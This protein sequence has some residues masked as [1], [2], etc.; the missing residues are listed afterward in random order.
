M[1]L[2]AGF[3]LGS[4][5]IYPLE[6][7]VVGENHDRRIQPKTMDVLVCLAEASGEVVE[8]DDLLSQVWHGRAQ[9]D[10][11]LT[12]R[13][14]ELRKTLGDTRSEPKYIATIPK[15]GYQLLQTAIP[16]E[17][18]VG[19]D[20]KTGGPQLSER[21][22]SKRLATVKK[23]GA[24]LAV[25]IIA[26]IIQVLVERT[27]DDI[28]DDE[29]T[30]TSVRKANVSPKSV[31]VLNFADLS[32]EQD[33]GWFADGLA[34]EVLNA[35]TRTPDLRV[36]SR[37]SSDTYRN[38]SKDASTIG[39]ELGV[40][41]VLQGSVRRVGDRLRVNAQLV[42]AEDGFHVWSQ[43]YDRDAA[44]VIEIQ[45]D[46]ALQIATA[47]ET[48]M[49]PEALADMVR[50]GTNSVEAY[51]DYIRGISATIQALAAFS[52]NQVLEAN[53]FFE[54]ARQIDPEFSA[55]H[56]HAANFWVY[57]LSPADARSGLTDLPPREI[58]TEFLS[59]MNLAIEYA[60]NDVD[61]KALMAKKAQVE[62]RLRDATQFYQ[63]YLKE[64]PN[65][66]LAW[67]DLLR[68]AMYASDR[69]T[70]LSVFEHYESIG[71]S[72]V[73]AAIYYMGNAYKWIDPSST[74]DFGIGAME[75]WPN[76]NAIR[77]QTHRS[78]LWAER[79]EEAAELAKFYG[80][81]SGGDQVLLAR[82]ACAEG[83]R[84]S[85]LKMLDDR[86]AAGNALDF[87]DYFM[88]R[89]LSDDDSAV[90]VLRLYESKEV[91]Y[92]LATWLHYTIVDARPF[93]SLM[94]VLDRE[95]VDRPPPPRIP[96]A[97]PVM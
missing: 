61:R 95:N 53:A 26:A 5:H 60:G 1:N 33:Q 64:R 56:R 67:Q 97:C 92:K 51:R 21:Q 87:T 65:D 39:S 14:G 89:F 43:N 42:R 46:L 17:Q 91:P 34:E 28:T 11:P 85:V 96:F 38:T 77:Y 94:N 79:V 8:R 81:E 20:S 63:E 22:K 73:Q 50:V 58:L 16:I 52:T 10:E 37:T 80:P 90:E 83:R 48:T 7:R 4:W 49:D 54:S 44:G 3:T 23:L 70:A 29:V 30:A 76:N 88:Y 66:L 82:Q 25:L 74:A 41:H 93:A 59:R 32:Q 19:T 35:L 84:E 18:S 2:R 40:A 62:L 55:A 69:D 78:L 9:T 31:A 45:E 75:R 27:V 6:G 57:Q 68:T 24:G 12:R 47:L 15:R 36:L 86:R 13:I 72:N 71:D